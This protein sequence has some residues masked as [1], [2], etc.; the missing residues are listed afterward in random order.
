MQ[1]LAS[2]AH[3]RGVAI[4]KGET[5]VATIEAR[6]LLRQIRT[7]H[8]AAGES[9]ARRW[10]VE[11]L[12]AGLVVRLTQCGPVLVSAYCWQLLGGSWAARRRRARA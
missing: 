7:L 6:E 5:I 11:S 8:T 3:L 10:H 2:A 1:A 12:A 9:E 4:T